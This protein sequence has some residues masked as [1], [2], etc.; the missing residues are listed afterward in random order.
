VLRFTVMELVAATR[1][2]K[3]LVELERILDGTGIVLKGLEEY[4]DCP[5]VE[6][7]GETFAENSAM[8][9]LA[10]ARHTGSPSLADDSGLVVDALSGAPGVRSARYAGEG[11]SDTDNLNRLLSEMS[12]VPDSG[13][14][15]RF[16]C[17]LALAWPDGKVE[18][19]EGRVEGSIGHEPLGE[20][21]FGYDPVFVPEG[22]ARTFAQMS[23]GE[24]DSMSHRGRALLK[25]RERLLSVK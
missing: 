15:A 18:Y 19:F 24:K 17:V 16:V 14:S 3:K 23:A 12:G 9:A 1:N 22:H 8:K 5:E 25:L 20:S 4:P 10:V 11:A 6:E 13:R 2:R 7:T 21:G